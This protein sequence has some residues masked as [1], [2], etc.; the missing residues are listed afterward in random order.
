MNWIESFLDGAM[1]GLGMWL[2][3]TVMGVLTYLALKKRITRWVADMWIKIKQEAVKLDGLT[4]EGK[5]KTKKE[6]KR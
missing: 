5:L 6:K 1:T 2:M 3:M 4:I